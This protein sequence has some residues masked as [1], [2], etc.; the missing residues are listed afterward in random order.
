MALVGIFIALPIVLYGQFESADRQMR[1]LVTRAIQDRSKLIG[2]ALTPVLQKA[3]V[4]TAALLNAELGKYTS[5]GTVLKLMLQPAAQPGQEQGSTGFYFVASSP[6]IRPDDVVP[7]LDELAHR[8]I[9]KKLGEACMWETSDEIRYTQPT[10]KVEL[11]TSIIPIKAKSGCWVLTSTHTTSE[12]LNTSI[13]RPYWET[14]AVRVAA[15]IYL[16]L[17]VLAV[18]AA[19]SIWLS[20]RRFRDVA[21]EIGLGRIGDYAFSHR[22]VVPELASVARGFDKLVIDLKRLSQQIR[23]SAEDNAHSFKTPIAAIQSSLAPVRR[24]VPQ[25][26]QR[27]RRAIEIIDSSLARLLGLVLAAQRFDNNT[28]DLI[29]AP[30]V[31]T[32]LTQIVGE[33]TLNFRE[34]LAAN[35]IRLIRRLDDDVWVEAGKGMLEIVLQ[36]ILENATSFSPRG[37][38][39]VLT[40]TQGDRWVELQVDDEG[41]GIPDEKI[42]RIFERYFSSRP[43]T[44]NGDRPPHSGLGLW[45][46]RRNI[47]ALGGQV[48][49]TN[50]IGGGLSI[51]IVLPRNGD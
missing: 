5:D 35:D 11:L 10:G 51:A 33:A 20:L 2:Y 12:F 36:N 34:I 28:A 46:V 40:L 41:P 6:A 1:E 26:D 38:T 48:R 37:G 25:E 23:Q 47:E 7:E 13:G 39:I 43:N 16:V 18:L 42:D 4:T 22:N 31:P 17:A 24:A 19:V 49:A 8:G 9:L 29:E 3:D 32:N 14:R 15:V 27:A 50:R 45:M 44:A 30:R 21:T